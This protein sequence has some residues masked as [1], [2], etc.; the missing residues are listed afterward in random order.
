MKNQNLSI[1]Q[2]TSTAELLEKKTIPFE[3]FPLVLSL[4]LNEVCNIK[5]MMQIQAELSNDAPD[6]PLNIKQ[7]SKLLGLSVPTI[8]SK[9]SRRQI[10]FFKPKGS[11]RLYF[12]KS[13]LTDI[14]KT[15]RVKTTEEVYQDAKIIIK[16]GGVK[17]GK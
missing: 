15:G 6:E 14:I 1:N 10:P 5:S 2:Q 12:S 4:I 8:Y 16:K 13:E 3:L 11:K 9:V 7:A 17:N